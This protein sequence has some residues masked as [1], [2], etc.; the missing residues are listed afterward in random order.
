[1]GLHYSATQEPSWVGRTHPSELRDLSP[2]G[3][4]DRLVI[5]EFAKRMG[6][7]FRGVPIISTLEFRGLYSGTLVMG[8]YQKSYRQY[9]PD[10]HGHGFL[11]RAY[12]GKY[13]KHKGT[14]YVCP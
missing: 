13:A 10:I 8:N 1:M 4:G 11:I 9:F 2:G 12:V 6:Y 5:W 14:P 7:H 3:L